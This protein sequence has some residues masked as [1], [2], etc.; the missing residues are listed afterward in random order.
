MSPLLET[1][2]FWDGKAVNLSFHLERMNRS[3]LELSGI[4]L[5]IDLEN[6]LTC[7]SDMVTGKV[8]CRVIYDPEIR[9]VTF[10]PYLPRLIRTIKLVRD[11]AISYNYKFIDRA[12]F[13]KLKKGIFQDDIL[14][15]RHGLLTDVSYAN[16]ILWDGFH[17]KTPANPLL[18]GT[19]R[20]QLIESGFLLEAEIPPSELHMFKEL[21]II[22]AM[23]DPLDHPAI[24]IS[25]I[26]Q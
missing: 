10:E 12:C 16:I 7:P 21:R 24:D 25:G 11:D 6:I 3:V 20:R 14:I 4:A 22:N 19:K 26:I 13:E 2:Q 17:W 23:L 5:S 18:A 1:I 9:S 8:K 15:V